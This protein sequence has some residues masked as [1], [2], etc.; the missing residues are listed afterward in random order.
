M[1]SIHSDTDVAEP[2]VHDPFILRLQ[3]DY[4]W[5]PE[6]AQVEEGM[7]LDHM[8]LPPMYRSS[9]RTLKQSC[10]R[11][12]SGCL[13][14]PPDGLC[15]IYCFL[16]AQDPQ[17]WQMIPRSE[18]GFIEDKQLELSFLQKAKGIL[19]SIVQDMRAHG[20][21]SLAD[22][23]EAGGFPGD[24]EIKF[25]CE[26]FQCGILIIPRSNVDLA[27]PVLHGSKPVGM[28]VVHSG[29]HFE[30]SRSWLHKEA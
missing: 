13:T 5:D 8:S 30:L 19:H 28:E 12:E 16:A 7:L 1:V 29:N 15:L 3:S 20:A 11:P 14:V 27:F 24:E 10:W 4:I 25:Y 21:A 17:Q 6:R 23:L 26:R 18:S 22:A 9:L 2:I